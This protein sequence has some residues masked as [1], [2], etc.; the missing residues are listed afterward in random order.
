MVQRYKEKFQF[1]TVCF[2]DC[3][4]VATTPDYTGYFNSLLARFK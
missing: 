4:E 3:L 2:M 1:E